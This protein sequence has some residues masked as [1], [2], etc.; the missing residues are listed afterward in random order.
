MPDA[1]GPVI[2]V[3]GGAT[4]TDAVVM[5]R[6]AGWLTAASALARRHADDGPHLVYLPERPFE[7]ER[8]LADVKTVMESRGRCMVA[9]SEG[10][11]GADGNAC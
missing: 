9:V 5:G 2:G 1:P 7:V 11:C 4:K 3:D 6:D 10:I 8:F